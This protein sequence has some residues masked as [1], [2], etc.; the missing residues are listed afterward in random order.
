M[1]TF[2]YVDLPLYSDYY[3]SYS[4]T[5]EGNAY[6][7]E[8]YYNDYNTKWYMDI[9]TEDQELVLAGLTL[10]PEYPIGGDYVIPNLSGFF[11]LYPIPSITTEK[12]KTEPESLYQYY[13]FKYCYDIVVT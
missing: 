4:V 1:S 12:Y 3:Y 10:N 8:I 5:L 6:N 11:F 13:T 9:Y 2:T 7:L